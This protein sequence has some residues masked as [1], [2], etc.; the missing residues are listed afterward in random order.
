M[1]SPLSSHSCVTFKY[2]LIQNSKKQ[3]MPSPFMPLEKT[4]LA[5]VEFNENLVSSNLST[6]WDIHAIFMRD[7]HWHFRHLVIAKYVKLSILLRSH[8]CNSRNVDEL[9]SKCLLNWISFSAIRYN[10]VMHDTNNI[11]VIYIIFSNWRV[12]WVH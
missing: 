11:I 3:M 10:K 6:S 1:H 4:F 7:I 12:T 8:R 2:F 9:C 5:L